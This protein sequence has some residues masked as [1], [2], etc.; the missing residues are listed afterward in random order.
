MKNITRYKPNLITID[1]KIISYDT[2][3]ATIDH[4]NK[5]I[6]ELEWSIVLPNGKTITTTRQINYIANK[7]GYDV[8]VKS[9]NFKGKTINFKRV[10]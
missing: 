6:K 1:N 4:T 8:I 3:V 2:E 7:L 5:Q 10:I 9:I